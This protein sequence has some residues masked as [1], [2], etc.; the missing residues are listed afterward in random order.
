M[1]MLQQKN[2]HNKHN[3]HHKLFQALAL[4]LPLTI[5]QQALAA[6][7]VVNVATDDGTG[8]LPGTLSRAI[9]DANTQPGMDTIRLE[10]D[11]QIAGVMKRL[12]DSDV[13][14]TSDGLT[15][16]IDGN[17]QYRPLFIKSGQVTI[18]RL[19]ISNGL[20]KGGN[21]DNTGAGAG[22]GGGLFIYDGDVHLDFTQFSNNVAQ[23]GQV[24]NVDYSSG[25]GMF[26]DGGA[27]GGGLFADSGYGGYG[28]YQN[29]D[30]RFGMGGDGPFNLVNQNGGFG[31]GGGYYYE[32]NM[33]GGHGGFGGGGGFGYYGDGGDGGFGG[34]AGGVEYV[35]NQQGQPG[36]GA[37]GLDA[38]GMGGAIF[39]RQGNLSF[40]QVTLE[41]NQ[42]LAVNGA[43]GLGG[44]L[45]V[46][47]TTT[48]NNGNQQG[49]PAG[50]GTVSGC[51]L[52]L[53]NNA[54][55]GDAGV[56][57]NNDDVFDLAGLVSVSGPCE[58]EIEITGNNRVIIDGDRSPESA[59]GTDLGD[60]AVNTVISSIAF[61]IHNRGDQDLLLN[62]NPVVALSEDP[63][64]VFALSQ[65]PATVIGPGLAEAF[66]LTFQPSVPGFYE[67]V[68]SI[69]SNDSD[70]GTYDFSVQATALGAEIQVNGQSG[71]IASGEVTPRLSAG[72]YLGELTGQ[73]S[74]TIENTGVL[75]LNLNGV[76][77]VR[78][79]GPDADQFTVTQQPAQTTLNPGESTTFILAFNP[80]GNGYHEAQVL[81]ENSDL[82]DRWYQFR[83]AGGLDVGDFHVTVATDDGTGLQ[84]NTLS[85]A[86]LQANQTPGPQVITL[87]QDVLLTGVPKRLI[88]SD[89][90]L[91]SAGPI[92]SI[93]GDNR[94]RPL[95]IKSGQVRIH[96]L[97]LTNG[98]AKGGKPAIIDQGSSGA[99]AGGGAGLGGGLFIYDGSVS[100]S[101][102]VIDGSRATAPNTFLDAQTPRDKG[103]AGMYAGIEERDGGGAGLFAESTS[104]SGGYGGYGN[105]QNLDPKFGYGGGAG[106]SEPGGFGAGGGYDT[107]PDYG[108]GIG[109][110]GGFGGGGGGAYA[111]EGSG[112][113]GR[114]GFGGGSGGFGAT[115]FG[116]ALGGG[117]FIRSG[118]ITL[119]HVDFLH[120]EATPNGNSQGLGGAM[121]ILHTTEHANGNNQGMPAVLAD[122][123][124]CDVTF[125]DNTARDD[126]GTP[127]NNDDVFDQGGRLSIEADCPVDLTFFDLIFTDGFD[128]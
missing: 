21:A 42:A 87:A 74:F 5:G 27:D 68:I 15:R 94:Q 91:R 69:D 58:Q 123:T 109:G 54:A 99:D 38:A 2:K 79:L 120:N 26:G 22:M 35:S 34:G 61:Q 59:D 128:D 37:A 86:I 25:G 77:P 47:H 51:G 8:L 19:N 45:F 108:T 92:V 97:D 95:F 100:L 115:I 93:D 127:T 20:A 55:S 9:L 116:A 75:P 78:L 23:G 32:S 73:A 72:T 84:A 28:N 17:S 60:T 46:L 83:I 52:N 104:S 124:A 11:V 118:Q 113:T 3:K 65:S 29:N 30:P 106:G 7:L 36:Y 48:N 62:G 64:N 6:T 4:A 44:G 13:L 103:G 81:I 31:G 122:V 88:D 112:I 119:E 96:R 71:V 66:Q 90:E 18:R 41:N 16:T 1:P 49:M 76:Q 98:R 56:P 117:V 82:S 63:D 110:D 12:I 101:S 105:Y 85:W 107:G 121:F 70:E 67:A 39:L 57:G 24:L 125:V 40:N 102:V 111:Y 10:T 33:N 80:S 43:K 53:I 14:L 114:G 89:V 50:L 126:A